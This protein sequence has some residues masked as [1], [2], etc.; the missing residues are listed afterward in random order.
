MGMHEARGTLAKAFK[1]LTLR[2]QD[3]RGQWDDVQA[4]QFEE[5]FIRP[6][7]SDL[8]TAASAMDQM[9][10]LLHQARRDCE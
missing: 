4:E 7:E 2:W 3:T 8:R 10:I 6:L 1:E 9:A 5:N